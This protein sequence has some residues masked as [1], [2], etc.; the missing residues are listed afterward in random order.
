MELM[1]ALAIVGIIALVGF[2][3]IKDAMSKTN[4][5]SA[6]VAAGTYVATARA[7]AI[8][9]GC[10][11][12]VHFASSPGT[13]W[14]TV[15]PRMTTTGSGT[16]DTVGVVEELATLYNV[17]MTE[18]QDSVQFDP[19]G[20]SRNNNQST[21]LFTTTSGARDSILINPVGKVVR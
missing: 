10:D 7:A 3:K 18:T 19:R 13:V 5:R 20:L 8:Q 12:V 17:T 2:P 15:C 6:R 4:V 1:V 14:V 16:I 11:G 9:R 21:V